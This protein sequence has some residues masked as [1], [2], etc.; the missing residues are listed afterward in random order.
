MKPMDLEIRDLA[1][2]R[3]RRRRRKRPYPIDLANRPDPP[4]KHDQALASVAWWGLLTL[5]ALTLAVICSFD[6][7]F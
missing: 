5:G 4:G 7:A 2:Y 6:G 3:A 1:F